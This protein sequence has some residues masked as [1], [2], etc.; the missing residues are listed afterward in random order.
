MKKII[1]IICGILI[2]LIGS[3][4]IYNHIYFKDLKSTYESVESQYPSYELTLLS[5]GKFKVVDIGAGNPV[6]KGRLLKIPF[7][8][9]K[10]IINCSL[11]DDFDYTFLNLKKKVKIVDMW[12]MGIGDASNNYE[13]YLAIIFE[14]GKEH[15]Q[16]NQMH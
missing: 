7:T 16:F 11:D 15:V 6:I 1:F 9:S 5:S 4:C 8:E 14:N 13:S 3:Y 12:V 10:Y 2:L